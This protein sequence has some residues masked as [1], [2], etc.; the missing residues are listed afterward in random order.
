ME[1]YFDK[2]KVE[3]GCDEAGRGCIA[4]PVVAAAVILPKDIV[5]P[6]L[7][8]SKKL[9]PKK[10]KDLVPFIK[11]NAISFAISFVDHLKIDEINILNASILAMHQAVE[12]LKSTPEL[13]LIDGNRF[14]PFQNIPH[15]CIV[16]G[17]DKYLSIAA[18][19]VLAKEARD[20][21]MR[22]LDLQFPHYGWKSNKG[23]PTVQHR[24]A[25]RK[26]GVTSYHRKTFNL[27]GDGQQK[28]F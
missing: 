25:I 23:Y 11:E 3:A 8:D 7:R 15:H 10:R 17:D 5:I 21:Y 2:N 4:G 9:T 6:G 28:L 12:Q 26:F 18:A 1:V 14:H 22:E 24:E 20:D 16:K 19:S 27:L 13:L